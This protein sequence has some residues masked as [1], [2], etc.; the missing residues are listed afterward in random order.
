MQRHGHGVTRVILL[1]SDLL[2]LDQK[3]DPYRSLHTTIRS[4]WQSF[5]CSD[6]ITRCQELTR[7]T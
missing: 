5:H 7:T 4:I 3:K 1:A 2:M 6:G